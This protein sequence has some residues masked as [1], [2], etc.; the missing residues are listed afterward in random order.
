MILYGGMS[1]QIGY[2]VNNFF[3]GADDAFLYGM[4]MAFITAAL[5]STLGAAVTAARLYGKRKMKAGAG[6]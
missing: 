1:S 5:V 2:T 3:E 4:R 6:Q